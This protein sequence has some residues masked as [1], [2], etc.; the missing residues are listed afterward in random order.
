MVESRR[1]CNIFCSYSCTASSAIIE[2][3]S[4]LF[5]V[6][7][8]KIAACQ[9]QNKRE[10]FYVYKIVAKCIQDFLGV[11]IVVGHFLDSFL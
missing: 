3:F 6:W 11:P 9:L 7:Q 8:H 4:L 2:C 5:T 10:Y 1:F